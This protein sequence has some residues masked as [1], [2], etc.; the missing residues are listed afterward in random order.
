MV[1]L[2]RL[3]S[4]ARICRQLERL[5]VRRRHSQ[6]DRMRQDDDPS[7]AHLFFRSPELSRRLAREIRRGEYRPAPT[8]LRVARLDKTREL[9][10]FR[11]IDLIV[12]GV[13]AQILTEEM[14]PR[15]P[16]RLYSYRRRRSSWMAVR[17]FAAYV[18]EHRRARPRVHS[19]G[20][21]VLRADIRSYGDS[22]P[23]G[24]TSPLWGQIAT[25][26]GLAR[27]DPAWAL[28]R[29]LVRPEVLLPG[30]E[31]I[32][33]ERGVATGSPVATAVANLYLTDL[34]EHFQAI[35]G[36]FY[37]RYG[38]D[39]LFAHEDPDVVR[40]AKESAKELLAELGLELNTE[41]CRLFF[42][43]GAGRVDPKER[44]VPGTSRV[45]YLGCRINFQ[46]TVGLSEPKCREALRE[47]RRRVN[48]T[49]AATR[50]RDPDSRG[51]LVCEA[52]NA[53]LDPWAAGPLR[54]SSLLASAVTDRRQLKDLDFRIARIVAGALSGRNG[55]RA[56]RSIPY[57]RLRSTWKLTSLVVRRNRRSVTR[58]EVP[59]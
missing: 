43:N 29:D 53:A 27:R 35:S 7:L 50:G 46:G 30:G 5:V 37:A 25:V 32:R 14:E 9:C 22:I 59:V 48:R 19:R 49:A 21:F 41:K 33:P 4:R 42:F 10:V 57:R 15:L 55:S 51:R 47:I 17:D 34:D 23:M 16:E 40:S 11:P 18:R 45:T 3:A 38:D 24:E 13:F 31:R 26:L 39:L 28:V 2:D 54:W 6:S 52:V 56:F 20:L 36:G 58:K 12:Q 8:R 1:F 44:E